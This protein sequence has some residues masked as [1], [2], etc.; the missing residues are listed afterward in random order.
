[1]V[2]EDHS[3]HAKYFCP[4]VLHYVTIPLCGL[5]VW[6]HTS[7]IAV[8]DPNIVCVQQNPE[9]GSRANKTFQDDFKHTVPCFLND[10]P[11]AV[12]I[13]FVDLGV[14]C[15]NMKPQVARLSFLWPLVPA[16]WLRILR[17]SGCMASASVQHHIFC[18]MLD[19]RIDKQRK[20][21]TTWS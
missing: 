11:P 13:L 10:R 4:K 2:I 15:S 5:Q 18:V 17:S 8:A 20:I 16:G 1:M 21:Q 19:L 6:E 12:W 9:S 3:W 7:R 14:S